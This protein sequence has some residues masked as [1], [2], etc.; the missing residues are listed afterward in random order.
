MASLTGNG[1]RLLHP[2]EFPLHFMTKTFSTGAS[3][4]NAP[5]GGTYNHS[6]LSEGL[7]KTLR[8]YTAFSISSL[9]LWNGDVSQIRPLMCIHLES[10]QCLGLNDIQPLMLNH[11]LKQCAIFSPSILL[12]LQT[13]L[14][15]NCTHSDYLKMSRAFIMT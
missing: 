12:L 10:C 5:R 14:E 2:S 11:E 15:T 7:G 8:R 6:L 13:T 4:E 3:A 1:R 9:F